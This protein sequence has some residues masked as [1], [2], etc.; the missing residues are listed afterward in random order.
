MSDSWSRC[1]LCGRPILP[2]W[3]FHQMHKTCEDFL[4]LIPK[5]AAV[6]VNFSKESQLMSQYVDVK[7]TR[8]LSDFCFDECKKRAIGCAGSLHRWSMEAK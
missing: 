2:S 1:E 6:T 7:C 5:G 4:N 8:Y 3:Q